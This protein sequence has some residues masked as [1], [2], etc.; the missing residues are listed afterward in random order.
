MT[1]IDFRNELEG[2]TSLEVRRLADQT[3]LVRST[4]H[5]PDSDVIVVVSGVLT[6]IEAGALHRL[7]NEVLS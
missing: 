3:V 1:R 6:N 2:T 5:Y 4:H 7:L